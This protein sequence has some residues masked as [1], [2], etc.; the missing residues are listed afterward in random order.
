MVLRS[1]YIINYNTFIASVY[2]FS[3]NSFFLSTSCKILT[4]IL[5]L[6]PCCQR[7]VTLCPSQHDG[8]SGSGPAACSGGASSCALFSGEGKKEEAQSWAPSPLWGNN[9][10]NRPQNIYLK[11]QFSISRLLPLQCLKKWEENLDSNVWSVQQKAKNPEK[12]ATSY[13]Q[14]A[15]GQSGD[16]LA[17]GHHRVHGLECVLQAAVGDVGL[18]GHVVD[19]LDGGVSL[20]KR[21]ADLVG[22]DRLDPESGLGLG[23]GSTE[24]HQSG[25]WQLLHA[26]VVF[27][28]VIFGLGPQGGGGVGQEDVAA[29]LG[30]AALPL[31][32]N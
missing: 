24:V 26:D 19:V 10:N 4:G 32:S 16:G 23:E 21:Y 27:C 9:S 20:W 22:W 8:V 3:Q 11:I 28:W 1:N 7:P 29:A 12:P 25:L 31:G 5:L 18:A 30:H 6:L 15:H 14:G 2:F 13:L 17:L